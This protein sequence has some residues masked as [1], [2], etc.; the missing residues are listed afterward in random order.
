MVPK[1][2]AALNRDDSSEDSVM[3]TQQYVFGSQMVDENSPTPYT[4]ATQVCFIF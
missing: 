1:Q 3:E 4:D 2:E